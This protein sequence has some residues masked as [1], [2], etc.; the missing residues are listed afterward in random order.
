M[1]GDGFS[2]IVPKTAIMLPI[3]GESVQSAR[4]R[5]AFGVPLPDSRGVGCEGGDTLDPS[6][7]S[8]QPKNVL[9]QSRQVARAP[10][11]ALSLCGH[12]FQTRRQRA[13]TE[14]DAVANRKNS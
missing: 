3:R 12:A 10:L 7:K 1:Y 13:S 11:M 4:L 2:G 9:L 5:R 6:K 8:H 14:V